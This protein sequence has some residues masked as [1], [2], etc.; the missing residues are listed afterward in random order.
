M[1]LYGKDAHKRVAK[2][3]GF[4]LKFGTTAAW[5]SLTFPLVAR[6]TEAERA[7]LA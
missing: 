4:A 3:V 2:A 7:G 5:H 1:S 6:L